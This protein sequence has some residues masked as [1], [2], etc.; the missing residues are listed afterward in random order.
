MNRRMGQAVAVRFTRM[1]RRVTH[2]TRLPPWALRET[3]AERE[4]ELL[5]LR[6]PASTIGASTRLHVSLPPQAPPAI[7]WITSPTM[8]AAT[9]T[10]GPGPRCG[11]PRGPPRP[12]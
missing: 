11:A 1:F 7:V 8:P 6:T 4:A 10:T 2:F 3:S 9:L 12:R 5:Y